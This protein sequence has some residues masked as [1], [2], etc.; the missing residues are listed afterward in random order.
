MINYRRF[1]ANTDTKQIEL[2][3]A[4]HKWEFPTGMVVV[5]VDDSGKIHGFI[6]LREAILIEPIIC[7][8][9]PI[10]A[11]NLHNIALGAVMNTQYTGV[12][13]YVLNKELCNMYKRLGYSVIAENA[14]V[15]RKEL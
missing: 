5:A 15:M 7:E 9:N 13:C 3:C 10:I 14:T 6:A 1:N 4:A 12:E 2:L 8:D 11:S